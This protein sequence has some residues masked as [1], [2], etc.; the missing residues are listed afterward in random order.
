MTHQRWTA[1]NPADRA[2]LL[3]LPFDRASMAA[4]VD[5]CM[6]WCEEPRTSHTVVTANAAILSMMRTDPEMRDACRAGDLIVADGM[7]VVWAMRLAGT[8]VPERVPGVDLMSELLEKGAPRGL[9]VYLLGARR[10]VVSRLAE[11]CKERYPGIVIAGWRD[12]YFTPADHPAIVE[13][14]R[15]ARPDLLFVGMPSP[16]KETWVERYRSQLD[17]PVIVGVGGSFD[18]HA[19]YVRRAP[20]LFQRMGMEWFWRFLM[21]PR[22][23]WKRY[24]I[25]NSEFL[26]RVGRQV[27]SRRILHR[28]QSWRGSARRAL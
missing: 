27:V 14:I 26:W 6:A 5:R 1:M 2:D 13:E 24:F 4:V 8:P 16:F 11:V 18:V 28:Q 17:V 12:G 9:R 10:E 23:M 25:T 7:S 20:Q 21:E 3:D 22:R 15:A 19:G